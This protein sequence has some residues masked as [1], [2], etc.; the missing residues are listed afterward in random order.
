MEELVVISGKGEVGKTSTVATCA[1]PVKNVDAADS[2]W[3][4]DARVRRSCG[5]SSGNQV[6]VV[7][8]DE[9]YTLANS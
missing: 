4:L 7:T 8:E 2:H 9:K 3:V 1:A 6:S 5:F